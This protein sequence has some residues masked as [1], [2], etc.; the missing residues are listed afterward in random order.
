MSLTRTLWDSFTGVS[1][2]RRQDITFIPG[3]CY[4]DCNDTALGVQQDS[5][6]SSI[7]EANSPFQQALGLCRECINAFAKDDNSTSC[8]DNG[9]DSVRSTFQRFLNLCEGSTNTTDAQKVVELLSSKSVLD[10][11]LAQLT[12]TGTGTETTTSALTTT[13]TS[14]SPGM[15]TI[16][17]IPSNSASSSL[18]AEVIAPS[19]VVP[20]MVVI[21]AIIAAALFMRR[22]RRRRQ[23]QTPGDDAAIDS[24]NKSGFFGK[25]ELPADS[26]R[27]ELEGANPAEM[28]VANPGVIAELPAREVV[29]SELDARTS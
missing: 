16:T 15:I 25:L 1:L 24:D 26:F 11:S 9:W 27:P 8:G 21:A 4:D 10:C 2:A 7:C 6:N 5:K 17:A 13:T 29:G 12:G 28:R 14:E 18:N 3:Q 23:K 22:R 20:V 19:V